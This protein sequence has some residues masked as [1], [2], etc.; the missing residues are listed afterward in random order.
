MKLSWMLTPSRVTLEN[1]TRWPLMVVLVAVI[2]HA[3]LC[4]QKRERA[5][6][7]LGQEAD[8]IVGDGGGDFGIRGLDA[9]RLL[10]HFHRLGHRANGKLD[11]RKAIFA[12]ALD[13]DVLVRAAEKTGGLNRQIVCPRT[14]TS[15]HEVA[16]G[17]GDSGV[18]GRGTPLSD[19]SDFRPGT[20]APLGSARLPDKRPVTC[21]KSEKENSSVNATSR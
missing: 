10:L 17:G 16:F 5:A 11:G 12:T 2:G 15:D 14:D 1:E 19:E 21:E 18:G 13:D 20:A 3:G 4:R 8:L 6:V 9:L 7:Q